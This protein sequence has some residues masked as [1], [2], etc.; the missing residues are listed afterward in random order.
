M[1]GLAR[2]LSS[3]EWSWAHGGVEGWL[4]RAVHTGGAPRAP[5]GWAVGVLRAHLGGLGGISPPGTLQ[6]G[7][8]GEAKLITASNSVRG[9]F[10]SWIL[11]RL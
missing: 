5:T 4:G 3:T 10:W 11:K 1:A 9:P 2:R 7:E 6:L 8:M